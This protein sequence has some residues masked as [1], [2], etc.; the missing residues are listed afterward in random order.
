MGIDNILERIAVDAEKNAE[1]ITSEA[2]K[3]ATELYAER[4][5]EAKTESSALIDAA[6]KEAID[7][8]NHIRSTASL[9]SRKLVLA[10]KRD[11]I[12]E[13]FDEIPSAFRR[14][15]RDEYA[16]F[17]A[18]VAVRSSEKGTLYFANADFE[19]AD[20]VKELLKDKPQYKVA[21][22][23]VKD[24]NSGFCIKYENVKINCSIDSIVETMRPELEAI[25]VSR[26][27][28]DNT[29]KK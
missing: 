7:T 17:L 3:K 6:E 5:A 18:G 23:T 8:I 20:K 26:L 13:V 27:F 12:D 2:R 29:E 16:S 15:P 1:D 24:I 25:V 21:K 11:V 10:A 22:T 28:P 19:V 14:M 9:E 4:T